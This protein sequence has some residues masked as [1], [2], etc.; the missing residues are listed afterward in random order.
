VYKKCEKINK[1]SW[2]SNNNTV[3]LVKK[4]TFC[5][6]ISVLVDTGKPVFSF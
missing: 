4:F 5:K 6:S 3:L 1:L 2:V